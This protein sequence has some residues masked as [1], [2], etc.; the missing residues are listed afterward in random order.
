MLTS[1]SH[2]KSHAGRWPCR[3]CADAAFTVSRCDRQIVK[4]V[5]VQKL[6]S[7]EEEGNGSADSRTALS[8]ECRSDQKQTSFWHDRPCVF[9]HRTGALDVV[10]YEIQCAHRNFSA[11][12]NAGSGNTSQQEQTGGACC[13]YSIVIACKKNLYEHELIQSALHAV[14]NEFQN[15]STLMKIKIFS[16]SGNFC[17][18]R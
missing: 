15:Q 8:G 18:A 3:C 7:V 2:T 6:Q 4:E 13:L 1:M 17:S 9:V 12:S 16:L 14:L 11:I 5:S 10:P